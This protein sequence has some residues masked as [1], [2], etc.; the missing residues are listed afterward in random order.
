MADFDL[1]AAD[2]VLKYDYIGPLR[3]QLNTSTPL[4]KRLVKNTRDIFGKSAVIPVELGLANG[5]GARGENAVLPTPLT[6]TY[7]DLSVD[8]KYYYGTLSMTGPAMRRSAKGEKGSFARAVDLESKGLKRMLGLTLAHDFYKG[9]SLALCGTT[10]AAT[11]VVLDSKANMEYFHVGMVVDI[12]ASSDGTAVSFGTDR[13]ISSV[14]RTNKKLQLSGSDNVT[15]SS[16]HIVVRASTYGKTVN[17]LESIV[18]SSDSLHGVDGSTYE[19]WNSTVASSSGAFTVAKLQQH[20]DNVVIKSG[21]YPTVLIS[22]FA[23]QQK[24]FATLT[25]N[26]RYVMGSAEKLDGGFKTLE[27]SAGGAPIP[28]IADRLCPMETIFTLHE[29]DLQVFTPGDWEWIEVGGSVWLPDIYGAT[30][31]DVYK[32]VIQ[33]D[34]EFGCTNRASQGKMTGVT[35]S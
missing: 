17:G 33:R 34:M 32:A 27:Y 21:K 4:L 30:G 16:S 22:D 19:A 6:G 31:K 18:S 20:I 25:A 35:D 1:S 2:A 24:Y 11:L 7:K 26:P 28:W 9:H 12:V 29:P 3:E 10:T 5:A 23:R 8:L 14:D 15:T 13:V